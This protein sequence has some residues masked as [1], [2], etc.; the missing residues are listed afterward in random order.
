MFHNVKIVGNW[1]TPPSYVTLIVSNALI[2]R[3]TIKLI[4]TSVPS[5]DIISTR[6][7]ISKNIRSF[8]K[9]RANQFT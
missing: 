9:T 2:A 7:G 5:G 4:P 8:V 3:A 6:S 1:N